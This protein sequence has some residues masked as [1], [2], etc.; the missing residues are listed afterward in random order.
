MKSGAPSPRFHELK[1]WKCSA[2]RA[3]HI[4]LTIM[5]NYDRIVAQQLSHYIRLLVRPNMKA[6]NNFCLQIVGFG[7]GAK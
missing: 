7:S 1:T 6:K 4:T 3:I 2:P 5:L